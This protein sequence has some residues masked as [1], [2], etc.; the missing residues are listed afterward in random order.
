MTFPVLLRVLRVDHW[1]KNLFVIAG[2]YLANYQ[3]AY[4]VGWRDI[5]LLLT[6]A[7]LACLISSVNYLI[8]ETTD[9][10][11]DRLHP[12]KKHRPIASG[13]VQPRELLGLGL[14]L[15][16]A[17]LVLGFWLFPLRFGISLTGLFI[18]GILYNIPPIRTKDIPIL[19]VAA[20]SINFPIRI[21][22]GWVLSEQ[23]VSNPSSLI[24]LTFWTLGALLMTGKRVAEVRL[25]GDLSKV[26]RPAFKFYTTRSL[27]FLM[28]LYSSG[29]L[30]AFGSLALTELQ[31]L[32]TFFP[33]VMLFVG[34][35]VVIS[36]RRG[37]VMIQPER[38]MK[39]Q[40]FF[41]YSLALVLAMGVAL[42][43]P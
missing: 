3:T 34:W 2:W 9:A 4:L 6:G 18:A 32:V 39:S 30:W 11:Y 31:Q 25:L 5:A 7:V 14:G 24:L 42:S 37:S 21:I 12:Y 29:F 16:G 17:T 38:I 15:L 23:V 8:N 28:A 40:W 13:L 20:E 10:R 43:A 33:F 27:I 35:F 1:F 26:Y 41:L 19:D 22:I 36:F